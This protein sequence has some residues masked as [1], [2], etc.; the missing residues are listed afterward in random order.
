MLAIHLLLIGAQR[1][2]DEQP[3]R[4][5]TRRQRKLRL[6]K[7]SVRSPERDNG[8]NQLT[9]GGMHCVFERI[10]YLHMNAVLEPPYALRVGPF[11]AR[12][13]TTSLWS[14]GGSVIFH[15]KPVAGLLFVT[16]R[17]MPCGG[18]IPAAPC[19]HSCSQY[20]QLN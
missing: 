7:Y 8:L 6:G 14:F 2:S 11:A 20:M 19:N 18:G 13:I 17:E 10:K 15:M 3:E 16:G 4:Q 5:H 9:E 12:G 1:Y